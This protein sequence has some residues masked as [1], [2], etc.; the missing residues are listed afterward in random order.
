M[1]L[2]LPTLDTLRSQLKLIRHQVIFGIVE[3]AVA[4]ASTV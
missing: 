2:A 1:C 3:R 4:K